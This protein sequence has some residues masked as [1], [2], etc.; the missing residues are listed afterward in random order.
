MKVVMVLPQNI[1]MLEDKY[2]EVLAYA[3]ADT[4]THD[5][6]GYLIKKLEEKN[7]K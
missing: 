4:L 7:K 6:L 5:E 3:T 1:K 2:T